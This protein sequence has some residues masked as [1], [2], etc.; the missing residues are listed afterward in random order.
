LKDAIKAKNTATITCDARNLQLFLAKKNGTWLQDNAPLRSELD[1]ASK[2]M[3]R[4]VTRGSWRIPSS[5]GQTFR[6]ER[7]WFTFWL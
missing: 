2:R 7:T 6:S 1:E 4:L 3:W 5:L